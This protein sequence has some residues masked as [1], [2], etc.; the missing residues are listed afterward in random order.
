MET[1]DQRGQTVKVQVN[2]GVK[3]SGRAT[4]APGAHRMEKGVREALLDGVCREA[5]RESGLR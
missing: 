5:V 2:V 4:V 1:F 3:P